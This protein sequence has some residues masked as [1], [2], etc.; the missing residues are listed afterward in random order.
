MDTTTRRTTQK[1]ADALYYRHCFAVQ[2]L[3]V[4]ND[5]LISMDFLFVPSCPSLVSLYLSLPLYP[6]FLF[7]VIYFLSIFY[8]D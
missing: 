5:A 4:D 7:L 8:V 1:D 3:S 6:S 2:Q